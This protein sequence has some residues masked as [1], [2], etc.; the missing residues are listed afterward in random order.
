[1]SVAEDKEARRR[2][3]ERKGDTLNVFFLGFDSLSQ[4]SF[5][6][7]LPKTVGFLENVMEAVVLNGF[8]WPFTFL[9]L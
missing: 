2:A 6:R 1:M 5:R 4:M 8:N 9:T 3:A 7:N